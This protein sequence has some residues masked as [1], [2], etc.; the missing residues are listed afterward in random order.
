MK[1][2]EKNIKRNFQSSSLLFFFVSFVGWIFETLVCLFQSGTLCDRG[3]L[4]LPF[5]PVYGA[6]VCVIYL[7]LGRPTDGVFYRLLIR[8]KSKPTGQVCK[9]CKSVSVLLY[10]L[11][12]MVIA[13]TAE[14][15]VGLVLDVMGVSLWSYGGLPLCYKGLICLPVSL[16]WGVLIS[17]VAQFLLPKAEKAFVALPNRVKNILCVTLGLAMGVDFALNLSYSIA[18][19]T[20]FDAVDY[21]REWRK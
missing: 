8:K 10:F 11:T 7:L 12:A 4:F 2:E 13:T 6:P 14:L 17:L 3:F 1:K 16:L 20:H 5:C 18:N 19:G 15:V 21:F 9:E